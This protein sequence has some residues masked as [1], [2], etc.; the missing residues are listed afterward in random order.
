MFGTR[1]HI[2]RGLGF[3]ERI[4][5]F[6]QLELYVLPYRALGCGLYWPTTLACSAI[7]SLTEGAI[8][9]CSCGW[10]LDWQ[11]MHE[12]AYTGFL[13]TACTSCSLFPSIYSTFLAKVDIFAF[14]SISSESAK[15][16]PLWWAEGLI[17]S[18]SL[19]FG[20]SH[21]LE[22]SAT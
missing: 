11:L 13:V 6:L 14:I 8:G 12:L 3:Q 18:I 1:R 10:P 20:L 17:F 7:K 5:W 15:I 9:Q 4:W 16:P 22:V 21:P 19:G 2:C